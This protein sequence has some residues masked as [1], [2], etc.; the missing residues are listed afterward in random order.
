M[1]VCFAIN[2]LCAG[3]AERVLCTLANKFTTLPNYHIAAICFRQPYL[4]K[5]FYEFNE[6][7]ELYLAD[8]HGPDELIEILHKVKPDVVVSFLNPMNYLM[9]LATHIEDIPHIVCER[10]NPYLSPT[11]EKSR[12]ERD[13]AFKNANGC[14]FQTLNAVSYFKDLITCK[15]A[16]IP[17]AIMLD[18]TPNL[19]I[20]RQKKIVAIGRY[21]IQKNYPF[22]LR[23]FAEFH[24]RHPD[25]CLCCFGKDSGQLRQTKVLAKELMITDF[26]T[27]NEE[28]REI[29]TLIQDAS[30]C[31]S[32]SDYEGM[33]NSISEVAALGIPC[34]CTNIPGVREMVRKYRFALLVEPNNI[35]EMVCAMEKIVN[36]T[37]LNDK[38][39]KNGYRMRECRTLETILPLWKNY[40]EQVC[41]Q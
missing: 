9:S 4:F 12:H 13:E 8:D 41:E 14:V 1:K 34:I 19:S 32:G 39:S 40:I 29:H 22:I 23:S 18:I 2:N 30:F 33:S 31:I 26:V 38:L 37:K 6:R 15:Y 17:N 5:H 28:C 7:V 35:Q 24:H 36:D 27:F 3:G 11:D 10:N 21:A 25:Y 16:T 20:K